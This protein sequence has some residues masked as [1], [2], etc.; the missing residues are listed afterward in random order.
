MTV[1][2]KEITQYLSDTVGFTA[3][4]SKSLVDVYDLGRGDFRSAP[5]LT[6]PK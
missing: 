6:E 3:R 1:T 2:K 4:D 5:A